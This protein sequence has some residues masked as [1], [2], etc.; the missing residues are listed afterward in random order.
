MAARHAPDPPTAERVIREADARHDR[1]LE[2]LED[3]PDLRDDPWVALSLGDPS[4]IGT[5]VRPGR[6]AGAPAAV[7]RR[8]QPDRR[9]HR[10]GGAGAARSRCRSERAGRRGVDEP[11]DGVLARRRA[12]RGAPARGGRRA[13]RQRCALPLG[14]DRPTRPARGCC[15][16]TARWCPGRTP[17]TRPRLR[18]TRAG[19]DAARRGRRPERAPRLA[20]APSRRRTP[21]A[22]PR[23]C[24]CSS[25]A[26]LRWRRATSR[27]GP[28]TS[29]RFAG[30]AATTSPRS[31][32]SSARRR[33]RRRRPRAARDRRGRRC[34]DG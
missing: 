32:A 10:R 21:P 22:R 23:S 1:A 2:L 19:A 27:D 34:D 3:A 18:A 6:P 11:L 14:G 9:R 15:W 12:A 30:A 7:L 20:T 33:R 16:R 13:E 28:P 8:A 25:S 5:R 29:T 24:G 26:G 4:R 31:C 17:F